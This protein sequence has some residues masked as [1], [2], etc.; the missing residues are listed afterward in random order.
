MSRSIGLA[1]S[2]CCSIGLEDAMLSSTPGEVMS[3]VMA[4]IIAGLSII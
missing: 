3:D 2:I 1:D 4:S